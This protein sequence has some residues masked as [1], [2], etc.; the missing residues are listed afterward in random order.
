[1]IQVIVAGLS[2]IYFGR[3][4]DFDDETNEFKV[5]PTEGRII[6][7][8][9]IISDQLPFSS[10]IQWHGIQADYTVDWHIWRWKFLK[11]LK[12]GAKN[13][14]KDIEDIIMDYLNERENISDDFE[15][16]FDY[17]KLKK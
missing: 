4:I 14:A 5:L 7:N 13:E 10:R 2:G 1:M 3:T 8:R 9:F 15:E 16:E 6:Q 17:D 11:G 12:G